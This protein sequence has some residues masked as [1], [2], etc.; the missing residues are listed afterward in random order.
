M[1]IN[2]VRFVKALELLLRLAVL[3]LMGAIV[4][5]AYVIREGW[6]CSLINVPGCS[7]L[8]VE[9]IFLIVM[10][11]IPI[12]MLWRLS[13]YVGGWVDSPRVRSDQQVIQDFSTF[14][15]EKAPDAM[16]TFYDVKRLPF[17]KH[18]I[19]EALLNSLAV[20][21][22][23]KDNEIIKAIENTLILSLPHFQRGVGRS[24]IFTGTEDD[25]ETDQDNLMVQWYLKD[26]KAHPD[27]LDLN[28]QIEKNHH[29]KLINDIREANMIG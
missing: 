11:C 18:R 3:P 29:T 8:S 22:S 14:I 5:A 15:L 17:S 26:A 1:S 27:F 12:A 23:S 16:T 21:Y 25:C 28:F 7:L 13:D 6:L 2:L 9:F 10:I 24:P 4:Y 19:R 20:A